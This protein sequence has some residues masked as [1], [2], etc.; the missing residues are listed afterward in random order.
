[1]KATVSWNDSKEKYELSLKGKVLCRSKKIGHFEW[2]L[3]KKTNLK[4][5]GVTTFDVLKPGPKDFSIVTPLGDVLNQPKFSIN[6]RFELL[7]ELIEMVAVNK[8]AKSCLITGQG[9]VGKTHAVL[10]TLKNNGLVDYQTLFPTNEELKERAAQARITSTDSDDEMEDKIIEA[11][12]IPNSGHFIVVRGYVTGVAL[13]RILWEH[14][15]ANIIFDDCDSVLKD[16]NAVQLLKGA[17]DSYDE[18]WIS[19]RAERSGKSDLPQTFKFTG[20]VI[21]ISN[22]QFD[23][24]DE[25]VR[26]RCFKV[27]L[28]MSIEQRLERMYAVLDDVLP[29]APDGVEPEE[30]S[31]QKLEAINLIDKH[32]KEIKQVNFRTLMQ[33]ITIRSNPSSKDWKKLALYSLTEN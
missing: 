22:M 2:L 24:V 4:L 18:R 3:A 1:V 29:D 15:N 9:G 32:K 16:P 26:S 33:T 12:P 8:Q 30:W 17:L 5:K 21:F 11:M 10:N 23:K 20:T 27:D 13:Y 14:A 7:N 28:A 6:E 31:V 25:A 19:W